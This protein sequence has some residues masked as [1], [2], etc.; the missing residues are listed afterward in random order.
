MRPGEGAFD[1]ADYILVLI[2]IYA[3]LIRREPWHEP[4]RRAL[5]T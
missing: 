4:E 2:A 3:S 5:E 1:F